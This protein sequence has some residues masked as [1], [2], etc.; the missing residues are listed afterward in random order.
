MMD[1]NAIAEKI[2]SVVRIMGFTPSQVYFE[3]TAFLLGW[4]I[5][6]TQFHLVYRPEGDTLLICLLETISPRSGLET[7]MIPVLRLW[8]QTA[9][10]VPE[11]MKM[12]AMIR[13]TGANNVRL[14]RQKMVSFLLKQG[15][16]ITN[17][18]NEQWV[19]LDR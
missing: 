5:S 18:D 8:R 11:L 10:N 1:N 14:N 4:E 6:N 3:N 7:V 12:R 2:N 16:R 9:E 15:A 19:E 13:Q 17:D